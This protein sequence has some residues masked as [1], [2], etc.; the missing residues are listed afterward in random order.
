MEDRTKFAD[1]LMD[2]LKQI[3]THLKAHDEAIEELKAKDTE[4]EQQLDIIFENQIGHQAICG[5][6]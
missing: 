6:S 4:I 5:D 2:L 1:N 3:V